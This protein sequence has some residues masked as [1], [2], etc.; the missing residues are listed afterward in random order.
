M[1]RPRPPRPVDDHI[2]WATRLFVDG[3]LQDQAVLVWAAAL[4]PGADAQ[5]RAVRDAVF[6]RSEALPEPYM[7]AWRCVI[8]AWQDGTVDDPDMNIIE[9]KDAIKRGIDPRLF[10]DSIVDL[11]V[12]RLK[13][14][15]RSQ[16]SE[17]VRGS[18][19]QLRT[20]SLWPSSPT[21]TFTW[22]R[23]VWRIAKPRGCGRSC[24]TAP[25][26]PSSAVYTRPTGSV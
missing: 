14:Q 6:S 3:R 7:T 13:I 18:P 12:P 26:A 17:P 8:E 19:R 10:I 15:P 9:I 16:L 21:I 5:R 2:R 23:S 20:C 4:G 24:S 1:R 25:K 22:R 11:T